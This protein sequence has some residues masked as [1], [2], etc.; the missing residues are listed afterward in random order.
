MRTM[1]HIV[2]PVVVGKES[3][4]RVAQP[5]TFE[6]MRI[7]RE[8]AS[9]RVHMTPVYTKYVDEAPAIPEDFQKAPDLDRSIL[10]VSTFRARRKLA[11]MKDILDRLYQTTDA[12]Y[13]IYTNVDIALMPHFYVAVDQL[14]D[15]G[16]D[17]L[18]INRRVIPRS[19]AD[20][21]DIPLMYAQVGRP[22]PGCDCFV[23]KRSA[24]PDYRLGMAFIGSGRIGLIMAVN[25]YYNATTF[26]Q[27]RDLH[28]TFHIGGDAPWLSDDLKAERAHNNDELKKLM[29]HY[30]VRRNPPDDP[31]LTGRLFEVYRPES[32]ASARRALRRVRRRVA[33]RCK[34][35]VRII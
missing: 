29:I 19:Y 10:D 33:R 22:H 6:T 3:D 14:I 16:Y 5:I 15:Q 7:A 4:L 28:L 9:G 31:I 32:I 13:L 23:F 26:K 25:L 35:I 21:Q 30:D 34:R 17:A 12:E 18:V 2:H 24:Y 11:L 20:I 8:F 27:F 1:A